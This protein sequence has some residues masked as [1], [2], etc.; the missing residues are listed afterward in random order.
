MF[1]VKQEHFAASIEYLSGTESFSVRRRLLRNVTHYIW[2]T[3]KLK[4]PAR[5]LVVSDLHND[6]FADILP[7]LRDID[8]LLM[9]GD[10]ADAYRQQ[11]DSTIVF[12]KEAAITVPTF[13][14]VGN[15]D[16]RLKDFRGFARAV[17]ATG[18]KFQ[19]NAYERLGEEVIGCWYR[20][21]FYKHADILPAFAAEA[22]CKIL[23]S[24]RPED[25]FKSLCD[26]DVDLVLS[27]H[28]HGGQWR[29]GNRGVYSSGQGIFP[30]YTRGI[31]ENMIISAGVSNRVAVPRWN[32][33]CEILQIEL[34]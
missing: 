10:S 25:Y 20:P 30:K 27:G 2:H 34:D 17:E 12:L 3:G 24:H 6:E 21:P 7:L 23:M 31:V 26:A 8:V 15:H 13:V 11:Y 14:G 4:K 32:N 29:I 5:L 33:P 16:M 1:S 18:A 22:G 28:S 19:F 9:P